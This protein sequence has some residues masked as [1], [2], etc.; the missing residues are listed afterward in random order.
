MNKINNKQILYSNF[1]PRVISV[2]FDL[3]IITLLLELFSPI[4]FFIFSK[5]G[6]DFSAITNYDIDMMVS[7][8][9]SKSDINIDKEYNLYERIGY[10]FSNEESFRLFFHFFIINILIDFLIYIL[11]FGIF[12][13]YF[14]VTPGKFFFRMKVVSERDF[15]LLSNRQIL[16]RLLGGLLF[17]VSLFAM[18]FSSKKKALHDYFA[19]SIVI[20]S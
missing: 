7:M 20:K 3:L 19:G 10:N 15:K 13:K 17:P 9:D 14:G 12:W 2:M 11:Y 8:I 6:Y 18:I 4:I 16:L 5:L 1:V